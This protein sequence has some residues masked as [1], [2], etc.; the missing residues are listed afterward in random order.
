MYAGENDG[1]SPWLLA[2]IVL[3]LAKEPVVPRTPAEKRWWTANHDA[4]VAEM[5]LVRLNAADVQKVALL[6]YQA[7]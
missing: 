3:Q 5:A 1:C 7:W 6:R 2:G 4:Q